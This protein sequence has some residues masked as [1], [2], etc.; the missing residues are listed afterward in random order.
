[1]NDSPDIPVIIGRSHAVFAIHGWLKVESF[2]RP[3]GNIMEY[4]QVLVRAGD[5]WLA[6]GRATW[7]RHGNQF[8]VHFTG[9]DDRDQAQA[10]VGRDI[11]VMRSALPPPA[12]GEYY[13]SDLIGMSVRDQTRGELGTVVNLIE[14]GANDVL[15]VGG[16]LLIPFIRNDVIK[17]IDLTAKTIIV[18]WPESDAAVAVD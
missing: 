12:P 9:I 11:A 18:D 17:D 2:T 15:V 13:W 1:M 3:R 14:T 4:D 10:Q 6:L 7:K 8:L 5:D 16:G